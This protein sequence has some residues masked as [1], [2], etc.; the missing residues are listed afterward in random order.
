MRSVVRS[1]A[2]MPHRAYRRV[3]VASV[4]GVALLASAAVASAA[5]PKKG[6]HF[7]GTTSGVVI[8]GFAP[9]VTFAVSS[10]GKTL[11][12]FDYATFGCVGALGGF[13]PGIDY[14]TSGTIIKVGKIKVSAS[15]HFAV[16]GAAFVRNN[17]G[18]TVTTTTKVSGSF[19]S[20]HVASGVITFT[21]KF[22][23]GTLQC[24]PAMLTFTAKAG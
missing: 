17:G 15:G 16:S 19:T 12:T 9:P 5:H 13:R 18:S 8:N 14:Y 21:Q 23:T 3:A 22:G 2:S 6:S 4:I 24:G 7:A 1:R 10:N 11:T 20:A